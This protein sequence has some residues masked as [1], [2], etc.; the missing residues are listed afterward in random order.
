M[1]IPCVYRLFKN[2][3][4]DYI[5][6]TF[7]LDNRKCEHKSACY[8]PKT[9]KYG[10]KVYETIRNNGG[11]DDFQFEVL[12]Y[13]NE[14]ISEE[15][16]REEEQNYMDMFEPSLNSRN[17]YG[18][19]F[20]KKRDTNKI[21]RENN[22]EYNK[23]YNSKNRDRIQEAARLRYAKDPEKFKQRVKND[24]QK[25]PEKFRER[26]RLNRLKQERV[27]C[28]CG[29]SISLKYKAKHDKTKSHLKKIQLKNDC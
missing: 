9:R 2:S 21:W 16:L 20:Q 8:N 4:L 18:E 14:S 11:F 13:Y 26:S 25:D 24:Y 29:L 12:E 27:I 23:E 1:S 22:K 15:E 10:I 28:E 5:G 17:A 7:D 6:S 19:D 3:E